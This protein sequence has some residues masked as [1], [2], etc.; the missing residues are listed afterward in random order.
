[1]L[2]ELPI[3]FH[4][5]FLID[6]N[7]IAALI[8]EVKGA[9]LLLNATKEEVSLLT[10]IPTGKSSGK[11]EP[12]IKYAYAV[13]LIDFEFKNKV[14]ELKLT[15]LGEIFYAEDL[16]FVE[17]VSLWMSHL[18]LCRRVNLEPTI[19]GI[20]NPW[21]HVFSQSNIALGGEF[22]QEEMI[23]FIS[24]IQGSNKSIDNFLS[25]LIRT[26]TSPDSKFF[27]INILSLNGALIQ[28]NSAPRYS[29]YFPAYSIFL[30]SA[31][32]EH[33]GSDKQIDLDTFLDKIGLLNILNW[34]KEQSMDW[35]NWMINKKFLQIDRQTGT[36]LALRTAS[37]DIVIE[38]LYSEVA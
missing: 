13:G 18:M 23:D 29:E 11:V 17:P 14:W 24:T 28:R 35:L 26:Y 36:A 33:L 19:I 2:K 7:L 21:C 5:T 20:I 22:K 3:N 1:M 12:M 8:K 27:G 6:L 30:F 4:E 32:D 15:Q 16:G 37:L 25:L 34:T 10:G 38:S 9:G 31:W